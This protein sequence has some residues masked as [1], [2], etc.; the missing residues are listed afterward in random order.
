[1][2]IAIC[3]NIG[4]DRQNIMDKV[5]AFFKDKEPIPHFSQFTPENKISNADFFVISSFDLIIVDISQ[6][7]ELSIEFIRNQRKNGLTVPIILIAGTA[8]YAL[9][10]YDVNSL[11]FLVKPLADEKFNLAMERFWMNYRPKSIFIRNRL[12]IT[13]DIVYCESRMKSVFIHFNNAHFV[14]I[15]EKL[16]N[17]DMKLTGKNFV[18]C[19]QSYIVNMDYVRKIDDCAFIVSS[20]E[21]VPFRKRE[22]QKYRALYLKYATE[23][24]S[25]G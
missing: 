9:E 13:D 8:D 21:P 3:G 6:K 12:Y 10:S 18:R 23:N 5:E 7:E 14:E 20:S 25:A 2:N 17:I 4:D 16:D 11:F 19:H 1:M 15:R 24:G 22:L